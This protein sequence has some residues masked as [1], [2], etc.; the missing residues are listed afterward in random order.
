MP[1]FCLK[2]KNCVIFIMLYYLELNAKPPQWAKIFKKV[3][4][5]KSQFHEKNFDQ[6]P[7]FAISKMAKNQFLNYERV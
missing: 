5:K 7:F 4:A 1:L 2:K 3:Q 6:S